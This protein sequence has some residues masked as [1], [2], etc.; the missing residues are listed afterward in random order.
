MSEVFGDIEDEI[1]KVYPISDAVKAFLRVRDLELGV[2][3]VEIVKVTGSILRYDLKVVCNGCDFRFSESNLDKLNKKYEFLHCF[4]SVCD[5]E[6]TGMIIS[7]CENEGYKTMMSSSYTNEK[8][9]VVFDKSDYVLDENTTWY[10]MSF[11]NGVSEV[12]SG[13]REFIEDTEGD[14]SY[15]LVRENADG[16]EIDRTTVF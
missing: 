15:H 6:G 1:G 12:W 7:R 3:K 16:D 2:N 8:T 13:V 14:V 11:S 4:A 10:I 5:S 9:T